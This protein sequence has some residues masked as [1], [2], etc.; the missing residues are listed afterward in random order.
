MSSKTIE[1]L[2]DARDM[3]GKY[4]PIFKFIAGRTFPPQSHLV[5]GTIMTAAQLDCK[6]LVD[7]SISCQ[8]LHQMKCDCIISQMHLA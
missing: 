8:M 7:D 6:C 3:F 2:Q 1:T 5:P 4:T